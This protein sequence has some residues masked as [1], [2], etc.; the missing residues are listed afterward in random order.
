[1]SKTSLMANGNSKHQEAHVS[2][3]SKWSHSADKG[4]HP[5]NGTAGGLKA[6]GDADAK[7]DNA[8]GPLFKN[9]AHFNEMH[10]F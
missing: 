9:R 1:M 10:M 6:S 3:H 7:R 4:Q 5:K 8:W 2:V